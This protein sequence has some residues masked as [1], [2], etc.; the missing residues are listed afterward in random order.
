LAALLAGSA[1]VAGEGTRE[2]AEAT[3][4]RR[5]VRYLTDE[6]VRSRAESDALRARLDQ[7]TVADTGGMPGGLGGNALAGEKAVA[8]VNREL[9]VV[10]LN[11][12]RRQGVKTGMQFAIVRAGR[13]V[14]QVRVIEA[15]D[16]MAGAVVQSREGFGWPQVRDRAVMVTAPAE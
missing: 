11:A 2:E 12:G 10:V 4:L 15:R 7:R 16:M 9:G 5:Q 14:A 3:V 13:K 6:L 8:A 1:V